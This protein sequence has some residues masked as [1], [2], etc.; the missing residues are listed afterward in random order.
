M[1]RTL[2]LLV[3]VL[4]I[5]GCTD[6]DAPPLLSTNDLAASSGCTTACDCPAGQACV[7]GS[8]ETKQEMVF[9]CG[10]AACA[11]AALCEFPDGTIS[12]CDRPDGGV[13]PAPAG[14]DGGV[15]ASACQMTAC[16]RG[17]AGNTFCKLACGD[18]NATCV[19]S[20]GIEHCV[21]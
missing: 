18:L 8:C 19:K 1:G 11:G 9:C 21:P 14:R 12:Q 17:L 20:G 6:G 15:P 16:S 3:V 7:Q 5:A 2:G 4:A 10:T 13:A